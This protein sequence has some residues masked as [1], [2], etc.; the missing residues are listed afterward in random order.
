MSTLLDLASQRYDRAT[1]WNVLGKDR[2]MQSWLWQ[3]G[4]DE[5]EAT[6]EAR[7]KAEGEARALRLVCADLAKESPPRG[8]ARPSRHRVLRSARD[9]ASLDPAVPEAVR[10]RVRGPRDGPAARARDPRAD[11]PPVPD[12]GPPPAWPAASIGFPTY[13]KFKT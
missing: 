3:M 8:G 7:G 10:A 12:V 11:E 9:T 1:F 4:R 2:V 5:G 13:A 6:G